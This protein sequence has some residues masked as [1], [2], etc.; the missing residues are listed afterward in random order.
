MVF[1]VIAKS[2]GGPAPHPSPLN[3][4]SVRQPPARRDVKH[5]K[6][7]SDAVITKFTW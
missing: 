3:L 5:L 4:S 1:K 2:K 6:T 7:S